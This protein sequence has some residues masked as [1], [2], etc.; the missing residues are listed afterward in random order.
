[1][2]PS[3]A[4]LL[5]MLIGGL[6]G[7]L[8]SRRR[9]VVAHRGDVGCV[10]AGIIGA[11]TGGALVELALHDEPTKLGFAACLLVALLGALIGQAIAPRVHRHAT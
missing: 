7:W 6:A 1:M 11:I 9:D 2:D 4:I 10:V 5:W 3:Y 8:A